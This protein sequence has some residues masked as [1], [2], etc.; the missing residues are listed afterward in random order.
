V[1][2]IRKGFCY[3]TCIV[4][5]SII[6]KFKEDHLFFYLGKRLMNKSH[7]R[8][9]K[10]GPGPGP[11]K[12]LL[13]FYWITG[14]VAVLGII[15]IVI[16]MTGE[17]TLPASD[18]A[19]YIPTQ[20]EE[21]GERPTTANQTA[22]QDDQQ[23]IERPPTSRPT[24]GPVSTGRTADG[25]Y[26]KG[27]PDAPVTVT[28]FSDFECPACGYFAQHPIAQVL[29]NEYIATGNVQLIFHDYPLSIHPHAATA[30]VAARCAG[31]QN[32]FWEY[33]DMLF[34]Q[35]ETWTANATTDQFARLAE[36]VGA[37]RDPFVACL[38]SGKY[39]DEIAAAAAASSEAGVPGTPM[40]IVN[41]SDPVQAGDLL[42]SIQ[43]ALDA[44]G[45]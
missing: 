42:S 34:Q 7:P 41:G 45:Q 18:M 27:S 11:S 21:E 30:A 37:E 17:S 26:Y 6:E 3:D 4:W 44:E 40:F 22:N 31:D 24:R 38:S 43:A 32:K 5:C 33:H 9:R 19:P 25:F 16:V 29:H 36:A 35:Q 28:E 14:I 23:E 1:L 13:T 2:E 8:G 12:A 10:V 20:S 39:E 15:F